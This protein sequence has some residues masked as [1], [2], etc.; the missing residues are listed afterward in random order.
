MPANIRTGQ[1]YTTPNSPIHSLW[2][3]QYGTVSPR[4]GFAYDLFGNGKTSVRAGYGISYER[5]FGNVTFQRDS[6][7]AK[8]CRGNRATAQL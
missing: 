3:P 2:N 5:N 8:L 6:E 1:V 7:S 4:I